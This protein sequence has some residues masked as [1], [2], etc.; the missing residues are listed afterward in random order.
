MPGPFICWYFY[1]EGTE[2]LGTLP[3]L[4][5]DLQALKEE[6]SPDPVPFIFFFKFLKSFL[7]IGGKLLYKLCWCLLYNSANQPSVQSVSRVRLF[8]TPWTAAHQASLSIT[9][10]Q[11]LL[12]LVSI[13]SV[14]LSN[15]LILC[16]LLLLLPSIFPSIRVFSN[17]SGGQSIGFSGVLEFQLQHQSFQ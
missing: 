8:A 15:H 10:S 12:K 16:H 13:E 5:H 11:S 9:N 6:G 17:E 4:T 2:G 3:F 1:R 14:M 7:L